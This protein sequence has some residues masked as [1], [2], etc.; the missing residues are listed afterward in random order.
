VNEY[1]GEEDN[2]RFNIHRQGGHQLLGWPLRLNNDTLKPE[3][4]WHIWHNKWPHGYAHV[5]CIE[6]TD[7]AYLRLLANRLKVQADFTHKYSHYAYQR[8]LEDLNEE[9]RAAAQAAKNDLFEATQEENDWLMR[10]AMENFDRGIT[11]P[12]NPQKEQII[13][14]PGQSNKSKTSRIIT[15]EEG[16]LVIPEK[17]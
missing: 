3:C 17:W 2:P 11:A 4:K 6:D 7:P 12:T 15:D 13:S 5:I 1:L 14:Y 8:H 9:E 10:R 16:G